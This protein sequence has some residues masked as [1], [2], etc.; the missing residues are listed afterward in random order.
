MQSRTYRRIIATALLL[1]AGVIVGRADMAP[2]YGWRPRHPQEVC[3]AIRIL[4]VDNAQINRQNGEVN[5]TVNGVTSSAGWRNAELRIVDV[6]G[7][8]AV[9]TEAIYEFVACPPEHAIEALTPITAALLLS[10]PL[11]NLH[12]IVVKAQTNEKTVEF[13]GQPTQP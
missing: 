7:Q 9:E 5:L 1:L 4:S 11:A 8:G 12:R 13:D 3:V 2:H 10:P 6:R